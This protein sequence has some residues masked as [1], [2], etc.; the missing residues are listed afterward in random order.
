MP[1]RVANVEFQRLS[2]LEDIRPHD[3]RRTGRTH[4]PALGILDS[5]PEALLNHVKGEIEGTYNL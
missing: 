4:I 5:V 1:L 2:G 3:F